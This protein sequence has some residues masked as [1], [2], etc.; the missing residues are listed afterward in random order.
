MEILGIIPV[1]K[2]SRG[3]PLKNIQKIDGLS[4]VE[5]T[6]RTAKK[7]TKI[8]R[9]ILSTDSNEIAKIAKKLK[10]EFEKQGF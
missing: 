1:R 2:N 10:V 6:I 3:I 7:S 9:L 4:L 5:H 8:S